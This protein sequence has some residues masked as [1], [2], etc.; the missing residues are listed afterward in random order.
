MEEDRRTD[1]N[2]SGMGFSA[3]VTVGSSPPPPP[4]RS[5]PISYP[6]PAAVGVALNCGV[7]HILHTV[8]KLDTLAGVAIKYGVEVADIKRLNGLVTDRQM[9]ALKT[10]KIPLP[11]RHPPSPSLCHDNRTSQRPSS[12]S[13]S[14]SE[15]ALSN[16]RHSSS[17]LFDSF[18]TLKLKSSSEHHVSPAI[19]TLRGYYNLRQTQTDD[20]NQKSTPEGFEKSMYHEHPLSPHRKSKSVANSL[21][22]VAND[23]NG[24]LYPLLS[25]ESENNT[26]SSD[27]WTIAKLLRRRPKSEADFTSSSSSSGIFGITS[28]YLAPR[29][30]KPGGLNPIPIDSCDDSYK[31]S[32][33]SS[34]SSLQDDDSSDNNGSIWSTT[35]KWSLKPD[36]QAL[37]SAA[38]IPTIA[39][40]NKAALD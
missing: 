19:R 26:S 30:S 3:R 35:S 9:F 11:G 37:S 16:R 33:T 10:L 1:D 31:S 32:S 25:Q 29:P 23:G 18:Q 38:I 2:N 14:N 24:L 20:N 13:S 15:Q 36:F 40:R 22:S 39:R 5:L 17:D 28:K 4:S 27:K 21:T 7:N 8:S 6:P 34:M 12:S